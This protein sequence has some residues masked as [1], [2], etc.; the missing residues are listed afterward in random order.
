MN[1][2]VLVDLLVCDRVKSSISPTAL[3]HVLSLEDRCDCG[4]LRL[5]AL[6][7]S[8][9][10]FYDTHLN[11]DKPRNTASAVSTVSAAS[12]A[13][14]KVAPAGLPPPKMGFRKPNYVH[15]N[16]VTAN[17]SSGTVRRCFICGSDKHLQRLY[18]DNSGCKHITNSNAGQR[19][20]QVN[21]CVVDATAVAVP[22]NATMQSDNENA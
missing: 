3:Q 4:W 14:N 22:G 2:E 20:R 8:L 11:D 21:A 7:E 10:L 9:D 1:Y 19:T 5:A 15:K 12:H 16:H 17:Q 18:G 6:V 13:V